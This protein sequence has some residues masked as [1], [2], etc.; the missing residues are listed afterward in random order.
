MEMRDGIDVS[1]Y[2]VEKWD[3]DA[4][5]EW[6]GFQSWYGDRASTSV[7]GQYRHMETIVGCVVRHSSSLH[8]S[9]KTER[10]GSE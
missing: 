6:V 7:V 10:E 5:L 9:S 8:E 1:R 3:G 2:G 4:G